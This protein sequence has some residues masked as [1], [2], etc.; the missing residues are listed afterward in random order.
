MFV[1]GRKKKEDASSS[2]GETDGVKTVRRR[3]VSPGPSDNP[4]K[5]LTGREIMSV[6]KRKG[7]V[8]DIDMSVEDTVSA[9]AAAAASMV[10][11]HHN[12]DVT[13][14]PDSTSSMAPSPDV[15][16]GSREVGDLPVS[17]S[18]S[19]PIPSSH[20]PSSHNPG[21]HNSGG[22]NPGSETA[23]ADTSTHCIIDADTPKTLTATAPRSATDQPLNTPALPAAGLTLAQTGFTCKDCSQWFTHS[24][25]L[26]RHQLS[27]TTST[28]LKT[29]R[30]TAG[31]SCMG[32]TNLAVE[33][34]PMET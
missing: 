23:A 18:A 24:T 30:D 16:T 15:D 7:G 22:H 26:A 12:S 6:M 17:V 13:L 31:L 5:G 19:E 11:S 14:K 32:G 3:L 25:M 33:Q 4:C 8:I 9:V 1:G 20:N 34:K 27:H 28:T 29:H 10:Q 2:G 21:G